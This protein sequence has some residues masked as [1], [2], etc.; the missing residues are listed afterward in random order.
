[1]RRGRSPATVPPGTK[2]K[3]AELSLDCFIA[4][5]NGPF[6]IHRGVY[7][8]PGYIPDMPRGFACVRTLSIY[9]S[10]QHQYAGEEDAGRAVE[11]LGAVV[12]PGTSVFA[13]ELVPRSLSRC[14]RDIGALQYGPYA[15]FVHLVA[16]S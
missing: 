5:P 2:E 1:M 6:D 13:P 15:E 12:F 8:V 16:Y 11:R 7:N 9:R 10:F 3:P 14:E 4:D